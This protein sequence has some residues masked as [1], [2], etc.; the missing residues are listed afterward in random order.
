M[1]RC[2]VPLLQ[3]GMPSLGLPPQ[4]LRQQPNDVHFQQEAGNEV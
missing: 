2:L 4:D 1:S 3:L